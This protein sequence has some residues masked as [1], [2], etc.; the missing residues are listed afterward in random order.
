MII[1]E[2]K[3]TMT[4]NVKHGRIMVITTIMMMSVGAVQC[5]SL[6]YTRWLQY[7]VSMTL[8]P[9]DSIRLR[10]EHSNLQSWAQ[11]NRFR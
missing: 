1:S 6:S 4:I 7:N 10:S 11:V 2:K 9:I 3:T 8:W 5:L